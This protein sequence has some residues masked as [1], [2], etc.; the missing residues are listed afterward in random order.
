MCL[1]KQ[2]V[3]RADDQSEHTLLRSH[4]GGT[5]WKFH[6]QKEIC[7]NRAHELHVKPK[8][9]RFVIGIS[10]CYGFSETL[11]NLKIHEFGQIVNFNL[12][13]IN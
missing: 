3:K 10:G 11:R 5:N 6:G 8:I 1:L 2:R 9:S 7:V 13:A 4:E 12:F